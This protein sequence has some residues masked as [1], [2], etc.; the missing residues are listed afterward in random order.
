MTKGYSIL[1]QT[2][3][4][5]SASELDLRTFYGKCIKRINTVIFGFDLLSLPNEGMRKS[6]S[7]SCF[8]IY[9]PTHIAI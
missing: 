6:W 5:K 2:T 8:F 4:R 9:F 7:L 1:L 3:L